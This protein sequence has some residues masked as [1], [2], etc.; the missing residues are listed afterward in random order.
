MVKRLLVM[1]FLRVFEQTNKIDLTQFSYWYSQSGT[2]IVTLD[3]SYDAITKQV[4]LTMAQSHSE[5]FVQE[6]KKL[7]C[8]PIKISLLSAE[9]CELDFKLAGD[10]QYSN[11][12]VLKLTDE[13]QC[14]VLN[15]VTTKPI[16]SVLRGFT[17]PIKLNCLRS[18]EEL[19]F[20]FKNDTDTFSRW[21]SGQQL[22][23]KTLLNLVF[24]IQQG[25]ILHLNQIIID[26]FKYILS[27]SWDDLSYLSLLLS[28]PS[29]VYLAEQMKVIDVVAIHK[30]REFVRVTLANELN[31][32]FKDYYLNYHKSEED[33][34]FD[35][36]A[37]SNRKIKNICLYYLSTLDCLSIQNWVLKQ[38][39][40]TT[41]MTDQIAALS[42]MV[43][44]HHPYSDQSL[45]VFYNKWQ[46]ESLVI[47]KWFSVQAGSCASTTF[48]VVKSLMEH[49]EFDLKNPNR[50]RALL[51]TFSQANP[52]H[53]HAVNG[54]GY[55][56]L[57]DTIIALN[58]INPQIAAK[59][60]VSLT[61]W[62]R[63]DENRQALM[64]SQLQR[65]ISIQHISKDVYEVVKKSLVHCH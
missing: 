64:I 41:N 58:E 40:T 54:Q 26:T 57:A 4:K 7:L 56:L 46:S 27:Q 32:F 10:D 48:F 38:F 49:H 33:C 22:L 19:A 52:L 45:D 35:Q 2:P 11:E 47:D 24:D 62:R 15:E 37:I 23:E 60:A 14:V 55:Q 21:E 6:Y 63:Y 16:L 3:Y 20:L 28:I 9:G 39:M 34:C 44:G 29:E 1:I 25:N 51:G 17:S 59:M 18:Y 30:A 42:I 5:S 8:I 13:K 50:V 43:N 53:F 61:A 31:H 12:I 65:I 36:K